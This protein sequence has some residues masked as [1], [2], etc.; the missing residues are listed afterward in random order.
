MFFTTDFD[1]ILLLQNAAAYIALEWFFEENL[2][3]ISEL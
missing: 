3:I 2:S 1:L